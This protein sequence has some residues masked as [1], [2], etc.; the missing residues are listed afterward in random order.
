MAGKLILHRAYTVLLL[1]RRGD[2]IWATVAAVGCR[3]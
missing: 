1:G 3:R 2:E